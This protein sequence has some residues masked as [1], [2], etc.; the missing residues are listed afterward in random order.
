MAVTKI[1]V[2]KE[3][4]TA[5]KP[6]KYFHEAPQ[7][8]PPLSIYS[9][10]LFCTWSAP[11]FYLKITEIRW[12]C[13]GGEEEE[14]EITRK[15]AG[16]QNVIY[17]EIF[18]FFFSLSIFLVPYALEYSLFKW[19]WSQPHLGVPKVPRHSVNVIQTKSIYQLKTF[20]TIDTRVV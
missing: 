5:Q 7:R 19:Q 4:V 14:N 13:L 8:G 11:N 1:E 18:I 6:L 20:V 10:N 9:M 12:Q 15:D 3:K 17:L 16:I 2:P